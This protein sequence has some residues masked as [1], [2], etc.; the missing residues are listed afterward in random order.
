MI[1]FN[2][3][4]FYILMQKMISCINMFTTIMVYGILCECY[5]GLIVHQQ[6]YCRLLSPQHICNQSVQPYALACCCSGCYILGFTRRQGNYSLLLRSPGDKA[7]SKE[8]T[9]S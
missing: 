9:N 5:R 3:A 6:L 1:N 8:I 4:F 7:T 2:L